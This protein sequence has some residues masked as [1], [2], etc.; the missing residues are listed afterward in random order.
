MAESGGFYDC[1]PVYSDL[2][3]QVLS[4]DSGAVKP[5][6]DPPV[7]AVLMETGY[8][9]A[10]ATLV[11]VA[12][13]SVSL[14]FSSGGGTIGVGENVPVARASKGFLSDAARAT[15]NL[16]PSQKHPLPQPGHV[17]FS[18]VTPSGV[19]SSEA[20]ETI[21]ATTDTSCRRSFTRGMK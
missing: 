5:V 14:Y 16:S 6:G 20:S 10:V 11:C 2:R 4:L 12:D 7:L 9:E 15:S 1:V 21:S 19:H 18:L 17:R 13:G 3:A 8:P